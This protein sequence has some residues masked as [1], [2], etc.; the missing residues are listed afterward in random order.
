M[1]YRW[2]LEY[3]REVRP[4]VGSHDQSLTRAERRAR[5]AAMD[6]EN[7]VVHADGTRERVGGEMR[8]GSESRAGMPPT[9]GTDDGA[10]DVAKPQLWLLDQDSS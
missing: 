7:I 5:V 10:L 8:R 9:G 4:A 3:G 2:V 6:G 1:E